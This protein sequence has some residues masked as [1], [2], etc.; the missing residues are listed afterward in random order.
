MAAPTYATDL[1]NIF[2][3]EGTGNWTAIG[4][5]PAGLNQETDYFIQGNSCCSKDAWS[6]ATKGMI[7]NFG[8]GVTIP[9]DGAAFLWITHH[10]PNSLDT[11]AGAGLQFIIGSS[12]TA[13][14]HFYVGGSDTIEYGGWVFAAVDPAQSAD[15]TTGSP[16]STRQYFGGLADLPSGGPSKGSPFGLDA[17]RYGRGEF[18]CTN[19]ETANY[20]NFSGASD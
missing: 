8:S 17:I 7:Y 6:S 1:S 4:G 13:Y 12:A 9:T 11:K 18:R 5:G 3:D 15:Q 20:A 16:T 19:G 14:K 2:Q 10:T